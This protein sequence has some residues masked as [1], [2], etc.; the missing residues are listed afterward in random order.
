MHRNYKVLQYAF[1]SSPV[2]A[3]VL[4]LNTSALF[5]AILSLNFCSSVGDPIP[6]PHKSK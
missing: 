6:N 5:A 3:F 1:S 2:A 4:C